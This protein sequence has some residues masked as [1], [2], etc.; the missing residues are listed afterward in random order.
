MNPKDSTML[1][2][3]LAATLLL[4]TQPARAHINDNLKPGS[5]ILMKDLRWPEW[6]AGTYYCTWYARFTP[7]GKVKNNFYG[8]VR[9]RGPKGPTGMF[10]TYWGDIRGVSAGRQ[11]SGGS[12]YGAEG[13]KGGYNGRPDFLRPNSWYRFVVRVYQPKDEQKAKNSAYAGWWVK[14]VKKGI[15]YH[16]STVELMGPATGLAVNG[17]FVEGLTGGRPVHRVI[18]RRLGYGRMAG[19]GW[20]KAD[21]INTNL[22]ERVSIIEKG[23]VARVDSEYTKGKAPADGWIRTPNQ[24]N[25]PTLDP[26]VIEEAV[27]TGFERQVSVTWSVPNTSSPQMGHRIEVF[28]GAGA[29][30]KP[31]LLDEENANYVYGKRYDL[32]APA[33]SVRLTVI[34]IFDQ[35]KS[36]VLPVKVLNATDSAQKPGKPVIPGLAYEFYEA[37]GQLKTLADWPKT[38]PSRKGI[39]STLDHSVRGARRNNYAMKFSGYLKAPA[40]GLY[41]FMAGSSD[42]SRM[43]IDGRPVMVNDGI[44]GSTPDMYPVSLSRG[45]HRFEF[46]HF[47]SANGKSRLVMRWEGPGF[48]RR[49]F[50]AA[51]FVCPDT[52]KLPSF[53]IAI[54]TP[55]T[56]GKL[57]DNLTEIHATAKM[58]GHRPAQ[59][60]LFSDRK[61]IGSTTEWTKDGKAVFKQLLPEGKRKLWARLWYDKGNSVNS[62]SAPVVEVTNYIE[63][64]APWKL[65]HFGE[66]FFPLG[67]RFK[68]GLLRFVGEGVRFGYQVVEGDFTFTG[69][70]AEVAMAS[71]E[72]GISGNNWV[73]LLI[74]HRDPQKKQ[75]PYDMAGDVGI[76]LTTGRGVRE[77][78]DFPDLGG[79]NISRNELARPDARWMRIIRRGQRYESFLSKDGKTWRK[80]AERV[81]ERYGKSVYVGVTF[82]S[83]PGK[84]RTQF[85]AAMDHLTIEA[86]A[87]PLP[88]PVRP[89]AENFSLTKRVTALVQSAD[90]K[91]L[92]ARSTVGLFL[93][94]DG[95]STW[96]ALNGSLNSPDALAVRSVA[97]HPKNP[98]IILRGGGR[99]VDGKLVSGLWKSIDAGK[100]WKLITRDIDFDGHGPTTLFGEVIQFNPNNPDHVIAAGET[101]G[102][103]VSS[104][105]GETWSS[106]LLRGERVSALHFSNIKQY[107]RDPLLLI[108]TFDDQKIAALGM[109]KPF[110]STVGPGRIYWGTISSKDNKLRAK[111]V[112]EMPNAGVTNLVVGPHQRFASATTTHGLYFTWVTGNTFSQRRLKVAADTMI[113][114]LGRRDYSDWSYFTAVAPFAEPNEP[115]VF[116]SRERG[117]RW[118]EQ[119]RTPRAAKPLTDGITCVLPD[120]KNDKTIFLCNRHGIF[121]STD[122]GQT[123][124]LVLN[125]RDN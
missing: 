22:P 49:E 17:G 68:G 119:S 81:S 101:K 51:D 123:Y 52:G 34:D 35:E 116:Y 89:D 38:P 125:T 37:A 67:A 88:A 46:E 65:A 25:K 18:E 118:Q 31:I 103:F 84:S 77:A 74:K 113:I 109:P 99:V 73:G 20:Y 59:V 32:P 50:S 112:W 45:L 27:V 108:G 79:G 121:R 110:K 28:A 6:D 14:D 64:G 41:M 4:F 90:G 105:A 78:A 87:P 107:G 76:Y 117:F 63:A 33:R 24:P 2:T 111:K 7:K 82:R 13:A 57:A 86:G 80:I 72:N 120:A 29:E 93:S 39:V 21:G 12:G 23:T 47:V 36:V 62:R 3:T 69:R 1:T 95:G 91:R 61:I 10:W 26:V 58:R 92:L 42:G 114:G 83:I 66:N 94:A 75:N 8:G 44:H 60:Q 43:H 55:V 71:K 97:I 9:T 98:N 56:D 5:D 124:E 100:I 15:W 115:A 11:F 85:S 106:V 30:G 54:Q 53:D 96:S 19:G 70:V 40:D 122:E 48:E 16:H 104:D 102:L